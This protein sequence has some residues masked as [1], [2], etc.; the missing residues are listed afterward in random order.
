MKEESEFQMAARMSTSGHPQLFRGVHARFSLGSGKREGSSLR[1]VVN[2]LNSYGGR[3][4]QYETSEITHFICD[5]LPEKKAKDKLRGRDA[6]LKYVTTK[7]V[8]AC[9]RAGRR[10]PEADFAPDAMSDSKQPKSEYGHQN[11]PTDARY[12]IA[13]PMVLV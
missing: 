8:D 10:L 6:R 2:K 12:V 9:I 5:T 11:L 1:D 13:L 4:E 3:Q 7:W